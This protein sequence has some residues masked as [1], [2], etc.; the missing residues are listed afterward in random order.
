M[1]LPGEFQLVRSV[2]RIQFAVPAPA[3]VLCR[4]LR[5][6]GTG[7]L[8]RVHAVLAILKQSFNAHF[9]P[10]FRVEV[11]YRLP[12][13]SNVKYITLISYLSSIVVVFAVA[14]SPETL[15]PPGAVWYLRGTR[16]D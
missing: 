11:K 4:L 5:R 7:A 16:E 15:A 13:K 9:E 1:R 3:P 10:P 12:R 2:M 14:L 8:A 6:R